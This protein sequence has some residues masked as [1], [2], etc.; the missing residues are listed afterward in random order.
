MHM[1]IECWIIIHLPLQCLNVTIIFVPREKRSSLIPR[2]IPSVSM[3]HAEKQ[4]VLV[5]E[6]TWL[7]VMMTQRPAVKRSL[8]KAN[9]CR[10]CTYFTSLFSYSLKRSYNN[11]S[12]VYLK[13]IVNSSTLN[14][15]DL[16]LAHVHFHPTTTLH[17]DKLGH[18]PS[19][20]RLSHISACNI[21]KLGMG[22]GLRKRLM[23]KG[24][25][26]LYIHFSLRKYIKYPSPPKC[27]HTLCGHGGGHLGGALRWCVPRECRS[28]I[29][30]HQRFCLC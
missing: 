3:L 8:R 9:S 15:A 24:C 14:F 2:P 21:E 13:L 30:L 26:T 12:I 23:R 18:I 19:G 10:P 7:C 11:R 5:S 27:I 25:H 16:L 20:T 28:D 29:T 1:Q 4:E 22:P 6:V 17:M